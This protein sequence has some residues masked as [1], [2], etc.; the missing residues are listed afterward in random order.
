MAVAKFRRTS[1]TV[2]AEQFDGTEESAVRMGRWSKKIEPRPGNFGWSLLLHT[3]AG[4][5]PVEAGDWVAKDAD[6]NVS[7]HAAADFG[8][9]FERAR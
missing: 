9:H 7:A 5:V 6:G 3:D 1:P 4:T 2:D 8:R